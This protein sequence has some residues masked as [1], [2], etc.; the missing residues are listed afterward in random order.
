MTDGSYSLNVDGSKIPLKKNDTVRLI[1]PA[2]DEHPASV[3]SRLAR[4]TRL[5][6]DPV[7][8]PDL[9]VIYGEKNKLEEIRSY[10]DIQNTRAAFQDPD[11][12]LLV[13]TNDVL[14]S[15]ADGVSDRD[16]ESLL[17]RFD[18][19][20]IERT[21]K[22]WKF[23]V[24]DPGDDAPLLLA[25]ELSSESI[26]KYAEPNAVQAA[27]FHRLPQNDPRFANQWHLQNTGQNGGIA[28]ADVD[29][30]GAWATTIGSPEIAVVVHDWGSIS[31]IRT[32][33]QTSNRVGILITTTV[34]PPTTMDLMAPPVLE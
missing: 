22:W 13:L 32:S 26:V 25:D 3:A 27:T 29:A 15:F 34:M 21:A 1:T 12:N 33:W 20:V 2:R 17:E 24:N 30:L 7:Y 18:G 31:I 8:P 6:I 10:R 5:A 4:S 16:R 19:R 9:L 23:R 14:I 28:G 11:G